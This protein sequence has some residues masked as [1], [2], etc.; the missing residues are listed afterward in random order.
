M[1][2][3]LDEDYLKPEARPNGI[4]V[5]TH[6]RARQWRDTE[7]NEQITFPQLIQRLSAAAATLTRNAVGAIEVKCIG[8]DAT[9]P[10]PEHAE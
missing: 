7:T 6:H 1:R 5:I 8:I 4:L 9:D 3:Q 10:S 2:N